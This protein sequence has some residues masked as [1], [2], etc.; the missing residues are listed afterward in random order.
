MKDVIDI[1]E[2]IEHLGTEQ[3]VGVADDAQPHV[4]LPSAE[5]C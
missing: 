1:G 2:D 5:R 4:S 3:P